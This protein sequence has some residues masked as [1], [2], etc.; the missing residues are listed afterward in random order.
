[1]EALVCHPL[2]M[3]PSKLEE[4]FLLSIF[5]RYDQ[6]PYAVITQSTCTGSK[7]IQDTPSCEKLLISVSAGQKERFSYHWC[8][9]CQTRNPPWSLQGIGC[10]FD[11]HCAKDGYTIYLIRGVQEVIGKQGDWNC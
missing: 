4:F 11:G 10:C 5:S 9:N 6:S 2:G 8:R 3:N 7:S 1:M